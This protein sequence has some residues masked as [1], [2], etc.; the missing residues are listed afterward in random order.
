MIAEKTMASVLL[1]VTNS[2]PSDLFDAA[3]I[4]VEIHADLVK[5]AQ[6]G[7]VG[8]GIT[9]VLDLPQCLPFAIASGKEVASDQ[10]N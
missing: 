1:S 7:I 4:A 9:L 6:V 2:L 5:T 10:K 8:H 3:S